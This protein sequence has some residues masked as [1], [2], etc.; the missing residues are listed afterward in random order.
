M[1]STLLVH[2]VCGGK[3]IQARDLDHLVRL[4]GHD[5]IGGSDHSQFDE[6]IF[7]AT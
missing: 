1:D 2:V 5:T 4:G 7:W 6:T 3:G